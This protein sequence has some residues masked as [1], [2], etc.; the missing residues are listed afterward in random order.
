MG[1]NFSSVKSE[2]PSVRRATLAD[3]PAIVA[4]ANEADKVY[5][6]IIPPERWREP[7]MTEERLRTERSER[8]YLVAL[9]GGQVIGVAAWR[10]IGLAAWLSRL[11]VRPDCQRRGIGKALVEAVEAKAR[12]AGC[13]AVFLFTHRLA[14]WALRFYAACSYVATEPEKLGAWLEPIRSRFS[15]DDAFMIKTITWGKG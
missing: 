5:R 11:F 4:L 8:E 13:E 6:A 3:I 15:E 14:H 7:F 9:H 12:E 2:T 1:R 10:V